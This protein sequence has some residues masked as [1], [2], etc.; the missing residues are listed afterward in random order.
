MWIYLCGAARRFEIGCVGPS[1]G[2]IL[3][4]AIR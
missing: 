2:E 4:R 3:R 1:V